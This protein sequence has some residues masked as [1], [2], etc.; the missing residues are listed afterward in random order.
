MSRGQCLAQA[1]RVTTAGHGHL[2]IAAAPS[3]AH[4]AGGAGH[5]LRGPDPEPPLDRGHQG[6]LALL[7]AASQDD[8]MYTGLRKHGGGKFAQAVWSQP[9]TAGDDRS[10]DGL[11]R[12]CPRL[13][14]HGT[15]PGGTK[16]V[17]GLV[18]FGQPALDGGGELVRIGLEQARR[19]GEALL[20]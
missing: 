11:S 6:H 2:G 8:G 3:S 13:A 4:Q 5:Q 17:L 15:L 14:D 10:L 9:V 7:R 18:Q 19:V 12:E 16:L 1:C 20:V